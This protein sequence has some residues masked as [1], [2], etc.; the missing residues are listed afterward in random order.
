MPQ[1][2]TGTRTGIRT[3]LP[4]RIGMLPLPAMLPTTGLFDANAGPPVMA[5]AAAEVDGFDRMARSASQ[6][7]RFARAHIPDDW[8]DVPL[9]R[10]EHVGY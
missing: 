7:R 9:G 4:L 3:L 1:M 5:I 10:L 2:P 6:L 8:V